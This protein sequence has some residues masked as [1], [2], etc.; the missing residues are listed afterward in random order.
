SRKSPIVACTTP[1]Y[2]FEALG[3]EE[4]PHALVID[5]VHKWA[6]SIRGMMKYQI[7]DVTLE[8]F[9]VLLTS[10]DCRTEAKHIRDFCDTMMD[11]L[12]QYQ[13][14][15]RT[16][17]IEDDDLRT[18]LKILL[19]IKRSNVDDK[20]C[21][22]IS[23]KK[24]DR[25][26][27]RE[28]LLAL[29]Q[30]TGS[31]YKYVKSLEFA[32]ENKERKPLTYV[33]GHWDRKLE[34]GKKA[35]F[36][37]TICSYSV[38]GLTRKKLLPETRLA[39]SAT[40]GADSKIMM[41][42][43][44]IEGTFIDLDSDFPIE[45]TIVCIP[46]DVADLSVKGMRRN[47]KNRAFR[48][49]LRGV[50]AGKKKGIRSLIIVVSED[51]RKK[52]LEF[53][54]EEDVFAMSYGDELNARE[55]VRL[56]REGHGDVLVGTEAQYGEGIDLPN[57]CAGF[58]F[59]LRPGYPSPDDPQAQF[60]ERRLGNARWALWTWR[61]IQKM[62]QA[63]GRTIRSVTDSGCIFLMSKQFKRFTYAGLPKWLKGAYVYTKTFD[64]CVKDGIKLLNK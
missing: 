29:D 57:G 16:S 51:E 22:A 18:M 26:A 19:R 48:Q 56:F 31:L 41:N 63:R 44:G 28:L 14:G 33:F 49:M 9:W 53:A 13:A 3:R 17:L 25:K 55:A 7:S 58:T 12:R 35:Q 43:T 45:N 27:D 5:E 10:I 47:D 37:L 60:E 52:V 24:I 42:E 39:M 64:E 30:F 2:F 4:L 61:V 23:E 36:V 46:T 62:L 6:D 59:Y 1:Y 54:A 20:I 50:H 38:S 21:K 15:K 40:I 8:Q 34:E 32:L 11:I